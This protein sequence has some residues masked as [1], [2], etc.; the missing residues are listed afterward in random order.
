MSKSR[1]AFTLVELLV[2]IAI[3]G[4]LMGL[5]LP[6][7][8]QSRASARRVQCENQLKQLGIALHLHHQA[9][10]ELPPGMSSQSDDLA[11][12]DSTGFL[13]LLPYLE[14][15]A[16]HAL[17]DL[18][19]PWYD[20][21]NY[22]AVAL[23]IKLL[24]CPSNPGER[25]MDLSPLVLQWGC[26]LPPIVATSD[27]ALCKGANAA[28]ATDPTRI[29]TLVRGLFDVN[30]KVR[31]E[32]I[33]DGTSMTLAAGDAAAGGSGYRVRDLNQP[34]QPVV[35]L[36]TGEVVYVQQAWAA[37]CTASTGYPYYGSVFAVTAQY[38]YPANPRDEPMNAPGRLVAPTMDGADSTGDNANGQDWVSGFRSLH[39]G[40]ANFLFCDGGVRFLRAQVSPPV[41][42]ALSTYN[43]GE[44]ISAGSH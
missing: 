36:L 41:Y 24:T 11:N 34:S 21:V 15:E 32:E 17:Y 8:Q 25:P 2:V 9:R 37:G 38:G 3:L 20:T 26:P 22:Q 13:H 42:R 29:P 4:I 16:A 10:S 39:A 23:P 5:L 40:G 27:Y 31:F 7:V 18:S 1:L 12:G 35:D 44:A 28:L 43:G 14:Q 33:R 30:S 19:K 6:A